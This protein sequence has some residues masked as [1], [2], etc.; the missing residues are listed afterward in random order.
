MYLHAFILKYTDALTCVHIRLH[1]K[2][3]HKLLTN[4]NVF[5]NLWKQILDEFQSFAL[6]FINL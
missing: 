1:T 3:T 2:S 5:V 4:I 6:N